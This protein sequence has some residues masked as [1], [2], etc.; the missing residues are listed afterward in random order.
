M[1]DQNNS[2]GICLAHHWTVSMRGGEKVLEQLALLFPA[3]PVFALVGRPDWLCETLQKQDL[4]FS[5][6]QKLPLGRRLYKQL[7]P[8]FPFFVNQLSV[9][10]DIRFLLSSDAS[11]IKGIPIPEGVP[12]VC[13]CH[14]P[15]RYL[16]DMQKT[17]EQQTG[18]IGALGRLAFR[19]AVPRVKAF[20]Q[21]AAR[22][23]DHFIANSRFVQ[24]R[25]R[26]CYG[27]ESEVLYPPVSVD[28]FKHDRPRDDFYLVVSELAPYKRVDLVVQA[29]R[30]TG[31]HLVVIGDGSERKRLQDMATSNIT[32]LGRS[33]DSVLKE[34]FETCRAFLFPQVEDFGIA[35]VEAQASGAPVIA[36]RK[37]G[38]TETVVENRTGLFFGEQ[39]VDSLYAAVEAFEAKAA[40]SAED[41]RQNAERFREENFRE[42]MKN[43]LTRH[44]PDLFREYPWPC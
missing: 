33:P 17:Y 21:A 44:Y 25:I 35:A 15:P 3:S 28:R 4:R 30:G 2:R 34:H 13:Y 5:L 31:R 1:G 6:C 36:F 27:R 19:L 43:I 42:G 26:T 12:H 29:F 37:G 22:R 38:A 7:M 40:W 8:F 11:V 16:W 10:R 9:P 39:S 24:E 14:S 20:D 23:V 32:F 41:C 18:G